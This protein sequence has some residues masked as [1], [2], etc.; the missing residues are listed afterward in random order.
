MTSQ[1]PGQTNATDRNGARSPLGLIQTQNLDRNPRFSYLE[2]PSQ[3]SQPEF[4]QFSSP[5]NSTIDES[6]VTPGVRH[7]LYDVHAYAAP[8]EPSYPVEKDIL[9]RTTS[10]YNFPP[11]QE[12]HPAH[13]APYADEH[14]VV[15]VRHTSPSHQMSTL[16]SRPHSSAPEEHGKRTGS[17]D[18]TTVPINGPDRDQ[19][20]ES[21]GFEKK[22]KTPTYNPDSLAGPN[23]IAENHRPGQVSHPNSAIQ[24]EWKQGLCEMDTTCC[25]GLFCPCMVYGKTQYRLSQKARKREA[26]DLL[27]YETCNGS[28]ALMAVACGFQ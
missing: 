22:T 27:G 25:T 11:P 17:K 1:H 15:P 5:T 13:F 18:Q 26:T 6:P 8:T 14:P 4:E 28:C 19:V 10:P 12:V 23:I 20:K 7:H 9:G 21:P 3:V 2:T 16:S 24:P